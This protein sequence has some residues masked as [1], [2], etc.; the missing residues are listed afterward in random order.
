MTARTHW[1]TAPH[2]LDGATIKRVNKR[3][4]PQIDAGQQAQVLT[5]YVG[6]GILTRNE[7]RVKLGEAP[8]ADTA[9]NVLA[10][11]KNYLHV[12]EAGLSFVLSKTQLSILRSSL[13]ISASFAPR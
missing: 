2:S 6:A 4:G 9:A 5:S 1:L 13:T 11:S 10:A 12:N 7:A 8:V 3:L